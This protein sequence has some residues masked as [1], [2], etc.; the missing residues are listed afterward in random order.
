MKNRGFFDPAEWAWIRD[1]PRETAPATRR[2]KPGQAEATF[3]SG[4]AE[5]DSPDADSVIRPAN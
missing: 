2:M 4:I 1:T 5:G 3:P